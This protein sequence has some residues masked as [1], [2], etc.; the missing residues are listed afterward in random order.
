MKFI[1]LLLAAIVIN[2]QQYNP[3]CGGALRTVTVVYNKTDDEGQFMLH[4]GNSSNLL[5]SCL[6]TY[7]VPATGSAPICF[8]PQYQY[9]LYI[10]ARSLED[11]SIERKWDVEGLLGGSVDYVV[12]SLPNSPMTTFSLHFR[13][14]HEHECDLQVYYLLTYF[15]TED[16]VFEFSEDGSIGAL[17]SLNPRTIYTGDTVSLTF[18]TEAES[19]DDDVVFTTDD[20]DA[21]TSLDKGDDVDSDEA[22]LMQLG[23]HRSVWTTTMVAG[24]TYA[25]CYKHEMSW[26]FV[27]QITVFG[28]NPSYY[29]MD[30]GQPRRHRMREFITFHFHGRELNRAPGGDRAKMVRANESCSTGP[31]IGGGMIESSNLGPDDS[32][33]QTTSDYI[34]KVTSSGGFRVCYKRLGGEWNEIPNQLD[35]PI[36]QRNVTTRAPRTSQP[37]KP[38]VPRTLEPSSSSLPTTSPVNVKNESATLPCL[39]NWTH[40]YNISSVSIQ[41][42]NIEGEKLNETTVKD[43]ISNSLCICE[44]HISVQRA[45]NNNS[46]DVSFVCTN[47]TCDA[48]LF[49][50]GLLSYLK[51]DNVSL[52]LIN[53]TYETTPP[54]TNPATALPTPT[55]SVLPTEINP[56]KIPF[57][58]RTALPT[59]TRSVLPTDINPT[60]IPFPTTTVTPIPGPECPTLGGRTP[61]I[62]INSL[63]EVTITGNPA[64][65]TRSLSHLLCIPEHTVL[66]Y[67]VHGSKSGY[68][69]V[70]LEIQCNTTDNCDSYDRTAT[71]W[72]LGN[73]QS[74]RLLDIGVNHVDVIDSGFYIP[75]ETNPPPIVNTP[76]P[77]TST[78]SHHAGV[79]W[80][81]GILSIIAV[82]LVVHLFIRY[83]RNENTEGF[84]PLSWDYWRNVGSDKG[85]DNDCIELS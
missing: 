35:L 61:P 3:R 23:P 29:V 44:M 14:E 47:S 67:E 72:T 15:R 83:R 84:H 74:P 37:T 79:W 2:A 81:I 17:V 58:T 77:S 26:Y 45:T 18:E 9:R 25:I 36:G 56:T 31:A 69:V 6:T 71:L 34:I 30:D 10:K 59:P 52:V 11:A 82:V 8:Q 62:P 4:L 66:L 1:V 50:G 33:N 80:A 53:I 40:L 5:L 32:V 51:T 78:G 73:S 38:P 28:S 76:K 48:S 12:Y 19:D 42:R 75:Q 46:Y 7:I 54:V 68:H 13:N 16:N 57:P 55:S 20:C 22:H 85:F 41:S 43:M 27:G 24:G 70:T 21:G 65:L 49:N 60:K 39:Q 64:L 63:L